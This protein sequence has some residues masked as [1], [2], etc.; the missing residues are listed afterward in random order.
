M[1]RSILA[2]ENCSLA[3][4]E[5]IGH[6]PQDLLDAALLGYQ[7]LFACLAVAWAAEEGECNPERDIVHVVVDV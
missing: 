3:S 2:V 4:E 7:N 5:H 1:D 6:S